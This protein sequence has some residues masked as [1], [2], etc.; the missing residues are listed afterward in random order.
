M[1]ALFRNLL[2]SSVVKG[3]QNASSFSSGERKTRKQNC[4]KLYKTFRRTYL[5]IIDLLVWN[6]LV[7][8]IVPM[9]TSLQKEFHSCKQSTALRGLHTLIF[10]KFVKKLKNEKLG[11]FRSK[12]I[13][14]SKY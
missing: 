1:H 2:H 8:N 10:M 3:L 14:D 9:E 5:L 11:S 13:A 12:I 4:S 6:H 7:Y